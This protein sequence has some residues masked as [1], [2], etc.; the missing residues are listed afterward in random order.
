MSH[1]PLAVVTGVAGAIG[2]AIAALLQQRGWRVIGVDQAPAP[3]ALAGMTYLQADVAAEATWER[4]AAE[5][6]AHGVGL[7]GLVHAA[8][9]QICAPLTE[10]SSA[11]WQR[12]MAV[13]L[14][15]AHLAGRACHPALKAAKGS[16]V[17]IGS[18]HARCTSAN[19]AA[20]A[21][22][23]GGLSALVRALAI[24]WAPDGIRV[25]AILP[26]AVDSAMLRDGLNRGHLDGA[27]GEAARLEALANRT[28]AGRIGKPGDVAEAVGF[29]L[30]SER[31]G[32]VTGAEW[33]IDG[34]ATARLSTE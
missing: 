5:I 19:I 11:D 21:A 28:V 33:V 14:G 2:G 6:D 31:A 1:S 15:A 26:G 23:K 3:P 30:D 16:L 9:L 8:A 22:S 34:G 13:N 17:M 27:D 29:L 10:T 24:E 18:V 32:F 7:H 20:Y 4:V 12:V 25:N